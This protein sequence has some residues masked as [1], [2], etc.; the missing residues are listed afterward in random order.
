VVARTVAAPTA[1]RIGVEGNRAGSSACPATRAV[2]ISRGVLGAPARPTMS[3]SGAT[4]D[5]AGGA[6][7]S[8]PAGNRLAVGKAGEIGD[9][10]NDREKRWHECRQSNPET[11]RGARPSGLFGFFVFG[12]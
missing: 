12:R 11:A 9:P 10:K 7:R 3:P 5:R 4:A 8:R 2:S 1:S 6:L